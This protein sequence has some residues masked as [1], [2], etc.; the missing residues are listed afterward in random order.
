MKRLLCLFAI[1]VTIHSFAQQNIIKGTVK[2]EF[3]KPVAFA[4][5]NLDKKSAAIT[6]Q[7]GSF[8][9][10]A[11]PSTHTIEI[12]AVGFEGLKK[13][14]SVTEDETTTI[15]LVLKESVQELQNV[16]IIGRKENGYKNSNSFS[17]TKTATP[18]KDIPQSISYVTKELMLDQSI[19]RVGEVV[20]NFS[21]VNQFTSNNDIAIRGFRV[22][23]GASTMLVN[24][25]RANSSFWKQPPANYLER[26]EVIKGPVSALFGNASPG[27][28]INRVTKK[29]L[30]QPKKSISFTTG[31]FNTVRTL[32]DFTG[33]M[34]EDKTLLYRMNVAYE[35]AQSFRDLQFDKNIVLAPSVS[36]L[37]NDKTRLNFDLVYTKSNS[38]LDR[39]QSAFSDDL[40]ST[41]VSLSLNAVND[42]LNEETYNIT[43]ALTHNF[44]SNTAFNLAYLRTSYS[45]D[46]FEHRSANT[47]AKDMLGNPVNFL[48][49]RQVFDRK[50]KEFSD[51][52]T[53][54]LTQNLTTGKLKHKLLLGYDYAQSKLP[55]GAAQLTASGYLKKDGTTG[56]YK[57]ADSA[58]FVTYKYTTQV[59]GKDTTLVLPKPNVP[60]Y[61][62]ATNVHVMEDV[63]KYIYKPV[64]NASST[65]YFNRLHGIY[66]Q[67]QITWGKLQM[68]VGLRYEVFTDKVNYT[69]NTENKVSQDAL[70]PRIGLVYSLTKHINAYALYAQGYNP[71]DAAVQSNQ[72]AGGPFDPLESKI[73]EGGLKSDWLNGRLSITTS[74]YQIEQRNSLYDAGVSGQPDL[75]VQIG[76]E[77]SKGFELDVVGQLAPN[78]NVVANYAYNNAE[79]KEAGKA[80]QDIVG[81]QKPNAPVNQGNIWTKYSFNN[82][83]LNGLGI[84]IGAN[85]VTERY[86]TLNKAQSI[87][88]YELLNAALYYKINRIQLQFNLNNVLNKTYWV[89]GYDYLRLFPGAPRNWLTTIS[90]TF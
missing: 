19:S 52:L 60:T 56:A 90:Y 17:G 5:V 48:V 88:G 89:G 53:A 18:I 11:T 67:D 2:D 59:N 8:S 16:E 25:L 10:P 72:G 3:G 41:P 31:S 36:F 46:L 42:H 26:V 22:Y 58:K 4:S 6:D 85:F 20:K 75:K 80:D 15:D 29:P 44:T 24:G 32:A 13:S 14:V 37:P 34:N 86:V 55:V 43:T 30:D 84:G 87:P 65:P 9:L 79:L 71:Q 51:N 82:K 61:D 38:R 77:I 64:Y 39:G 40:Y 7:N 12:T 70:L 57:A 35:N 69:K 73:V 50:S 49:E 28:T 68:L 45:E 63:T 27:G 83:A 66:V 1:L 74:I 62:L 54:Y 78:W 23:A 33:P 21:G 76:K 47:Y 81:R